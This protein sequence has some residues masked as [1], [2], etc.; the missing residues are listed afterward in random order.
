MNSKHIGRISLAAVFLALVG[1]VW[2]N[3]ECEKEEER[4]RYAYHG[5]VIETEGKIPMPFL[6]WKALYGER[7][8]HGKALK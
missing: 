5:W 1:W 2:Y 7:Y 8:K 6:E 3:H 4:L